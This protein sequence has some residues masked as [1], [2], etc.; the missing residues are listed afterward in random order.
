MKNR[1]KNTKLILLVLLV[2]ITLGYAALRTGLNINGTTNVS[3]ASWNVYFSNYQMSNATNITPTTEPVITGTTTTSI[4]Y[5]VDLEQ[6]GD[7]YEFSV[8]V[9]N[10]GSIDALISLVSKYNGSEIGPGNTIPNYIEYTVTDGN[11]DPIVDGHRL[12][13]GNREIVKVFVKYKDN[14]PSIL[15]SS[16]T[17]LSFDIEIEATQAPKQVDPYPLTPGVYSSDTSFSMNMG[18]EVPSNVEIFDTAAGA[19]NRISYDDITWRGVLENYDLPPIYLKLI[20]DQANVIEEGYIEF[21][22]TNDMVEIANTMTAGTYELKGGV[23]ESSLPAASKAI[24]NRNKAI[25]A[26]AFGAESCSEDVS[27]EDVDRYSCGISN[28]NFTIQIDDSGD[29]L[30]GIPGDWP[31]CRIV[32]QSGDYPPRISCQ[33]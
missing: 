10:G 11:G 26:R 22:I 21:E 12:D 7:I 1:K 16:N 17:S 32:P 15:P 27:S 20:L 8:E 18:E 31:Q 28:I 13:H 25:A 30:V 6:P 9:V 24:Y 5:E 3:S 29:V 19:L 23:D 33:S 4:S 2:C 14:D